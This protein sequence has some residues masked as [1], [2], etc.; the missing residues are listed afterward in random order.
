MH[1]CKCMRE[2]FSC[3]NEAL[4]GQNHVSTLN[5][6]PPKEGKVLAWMTKGHVLYGMCVSRPVVYCWLCLLW[7]VGGHV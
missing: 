7:N 6:A 2:T 4:K 5:S 3:L 1:L